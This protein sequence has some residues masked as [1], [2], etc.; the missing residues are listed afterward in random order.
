MD[1]IKLKFEL[2]DV[3]NSSSNNIGYIEGE[4]SFYNDLKK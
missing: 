4:L 2:Y 3:L 1:Y